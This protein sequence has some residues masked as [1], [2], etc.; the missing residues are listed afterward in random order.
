[1]WRPQQDLRISL[2]EGK[3]HWVSHAV[4][5]TIGRESERL[6]AA[7]LCVMILFAW[8]VLGGLQ[9][10]MD[11]P[12]ADQPG[13]S[14]RTQVPHD[15]HVARPKQSGTWVKYGKSMTCVATRAEF[16]NPTH[17]RS[18]LPCMTCAA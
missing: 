2:A 4:M 1:M 11:T 5:A 18:M 10:R 6:L 8:C 3:M 17:C 12:V 14:R 16:G 13:R 15:K 9:G 7:S